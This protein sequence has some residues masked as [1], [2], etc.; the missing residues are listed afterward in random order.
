MAFGHYDRRESTIAPDVG[1]T[2]ANF[3]GGLRM[4]SFLAGAILRAL[5][6]LPLRAVHALGALLGWMFWIAP[7][8]LRRIT[9]VNVSRCFPA[10]IPEQQ[11]SLARSALIE[12]GKSM[13]EIGPLWLWSTPRVRA[14]VRAVY[15]ESELRAVLAQGRGVILAAPHLGCWEVIGQHLPQHCAMTIL[16]RP[17][18]FADIERIMVSSREHGGAKLAPTNAAGVRQIFQTLTRGGCAGILPDQEPE[19]S[20]GVFAPFFGI[21]ALTMTLIARI[22][23]KTGAAVFFAYARRLP[24]G[25]GYEIH[26][27]RAP[28]AVA[29]DDETRAATALNA[30]VETCVREIPEQYQWG[31]RRFRARPEGE[32]K[33]Y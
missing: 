25:R 3:S 30:G 17:P 1:Y 6:L 15:G 32:R 10:L 2:G 4:R 13:L 8:R 28:D 12:T 20:G 9:R 14:L 21:P 29:D 24:Q 26:Y 11:Q 19:L 5:A 31:Y 33:F 22:A 23:R 18:R 27:V 16:Y 7:T